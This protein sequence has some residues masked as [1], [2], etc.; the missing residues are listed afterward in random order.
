MRMSLDRVQFLQVL[1][2]R[3]TGLLKME[4]TTPVFSWKYS[5]V[6]RSILA[7]LIEVIFLYNH[8]PLWVILGRHLTAQRQTIGVGFWFVKLC[9]SASVNEIRLK[10]VRPK[11]LCCFFRCFYNTLRTNLNCNL[12]WGGR[13]CSN[14]AL[15]GVD[16]GK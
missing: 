4:R 8:R 5:E 2:V 3:V 12:E 9:W 1:Q 15:A 10:S 7:G 16:S 14:C 11:I 13:D 6:L